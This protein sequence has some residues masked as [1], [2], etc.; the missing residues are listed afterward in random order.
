MFPGFT[1]QMVIC[2][3][4]EATDNMSQV[5][6]SIE[7]TYLA[8]RRQQGRR[9][10]SRASYESIRKFI[11]RQAFTTLFGHEPESTA[12][13]LKLANSLV[14]RA[15]VLRALEL[16]LGPGVFVLLLGFKWKSRTEKAWNGGTEAILGSL[17]NSCPMLR[18]V[19]NL[20]NKNIWSKL[21]NN[22]Q[23]DGPKL[24]AELLDISDRGNKDLLTLLSLVGE[25]VTEVE[26]LDMED[27]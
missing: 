8:W 9:G 16:A 1:K 6:N 2:L 5:F 10:G 27:V 13:N 15:E 26:E 11:I 14:R 3:K 4:A 21:V 12:A 24:N 18:R 19:R 23:F 20:A 25:E 17:A 7:H 22:E